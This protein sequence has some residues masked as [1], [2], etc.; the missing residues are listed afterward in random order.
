MSDRLQDAAILDR[1][2][3]EMGGRCQV[4]DCRGDSCK[5]EDGERCTWTNPL[6]TVCSNPR[7]IVEADKR[8]KRH[9][10]AVKRAE[11]GARRS[12]KKKVKGRAA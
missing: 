11:R 4:C 1:L 12:T 8:R 7:C 2:V 5:L 10:Y 6:R 9:K 3:R